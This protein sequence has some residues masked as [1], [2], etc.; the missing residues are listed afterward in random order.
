MHTIMYTG[1]RYR[2]HGCVAGCNAPAGSRQI[3]I[4]IARIRCIQWPDIRVIWL[5]VSIE[6]AGKISAFDYEHYGM[7]IVKVDGGKITPVQGPYL[8]D[9]RPYAGKADGILPSARVL[10]F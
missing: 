6:A 10:E 7:Q 5:K 1:S 4:D 8:S 2:R 3:D 9:I